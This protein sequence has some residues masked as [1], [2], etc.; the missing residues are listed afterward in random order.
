M[1]MGQHSVT[2]S[3]AFGEV[4]PCTKGVQGQGQLKAEIGGSSH[5]HLSWGSMRG[6]GCTAYGD[7]LSTLLA[8]KSMGC[9]MDGT[10]TSCLLGDLPTLLKSLHPSGCVTE[11]RKGQRVVGLLGKELEEKPMEKQ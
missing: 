9:D 10:P 11:G 2:H 3:F 5:G 8:V 1:G 6:L 4:K 7:A